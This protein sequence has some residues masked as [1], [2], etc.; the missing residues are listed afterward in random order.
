MNLK[1]T[2]KNLRGEEFKENGAVI[3]VG[4]VCAN[5]LLSAKAKDAKEKVGN[6]ELAKRLINEKEIELTSEEIVSI[7]SAVGETCGTLVVGQVFSI[8]K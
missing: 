5:A 4:D 6:Y 1:E 8:L 2:I 7:K 3:T